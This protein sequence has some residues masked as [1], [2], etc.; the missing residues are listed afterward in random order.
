MNPWIVTATGCGIVFLVLSCIALL[1]RGIWT[2]DQK[3]QKRAL[4]SSQPRAQLTCQS[5]SESQS[6]EAAIDPLTLVLISAAVTAVVKKPWRM[7]RVRPLQSSAW[8]EA[9]RA[10]GTRSFSVQEKR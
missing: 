4:S 1:M 8:A 9:G 6:Q 3:A 10:E 2:L 7:R 5:K